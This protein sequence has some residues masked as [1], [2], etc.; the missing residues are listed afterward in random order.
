MKRAALDPPSGF[1]KAAPGCFQSV[2]LLTEPEAAANAYSRILWSPDEHER[3]KWVMTIDW[4]A[5]TLDIVISRMCRDDT[6]VARVTSVFPPYGDP[7]FGG[8]DMDDALVREVHATLGLQKLDPLAEADLRREVETGK[9]TLSTKPTADRWIAVA[10]QS[11]RLSMARDEQSI[12]ASERSQN[13][14]VLNEVLGGILDRFKGHVRLALDKGGLRSSDLGGI[15]LVGGPMFMP[16]VRE[17]LTGVFEDNPHILRLL[18]GIRA[19]ADFLV[20]PMEAVVR[21]A[22][23]RE[24]G[25]PL[26]PRRV[27]RSYGFLLDGDVGDVLVDQGT[28]LPEGSR[29][30][31]RDAKHI[32]VHGMSAGGSV[33]VSLLQVEKD[34]LD[35]TKHYKKGQ[36]PFTPLVR[37]EGGAQIRV[38][39]NV[40]AD[41]EVFLKVADETESQL[42][43]LEIPTYENRQDRDPGIQL[44]STKDGRNRERPQ[45]PPG[46]CGCDA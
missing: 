12:P 31:A 10:G 15:I 20:S 45:A 7:S 46:C 25:G 43:T 6:G 18:R 21:G 39:L 32:G 35:G 28:P 22:L 13:W 3:E 29:P 42:S 8:F 37:D 24:P 26:P 2:E 36:Y 16:C 30:L 9:I 40:S 23:M 19:P 38:E 14:V 5:G 44:A 1:P 27:S 4:G 41:E 11:L 34:T 33:V 17:A